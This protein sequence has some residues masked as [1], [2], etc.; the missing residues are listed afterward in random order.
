MDDTSFVTAYVKMLRIFR[1]RYPKAKVVML[2]GDHVIASCR[3]SILAIGKHYGELYGYRVVDFQ[4]IS[5]YKE[6]K[7]ITKV[8]SSHPDE[9]G[10]EVM[11]NYIYKQVGTYLESEGGNEGGEGGGNSGS[12]GPGNLDDVT[13]NEGNWN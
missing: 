12:T 9:N 4:E 8:S 6:N 10:F 2:I 1:L 5:A 3:N 11:A 13:E 7:V